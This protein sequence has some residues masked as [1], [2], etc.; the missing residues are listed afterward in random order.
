M[1][2][3]EGFSQPRLPQTHPNLSNQRQ[4]VIQEMQTDCR[5]SILSLLNIVHIAIA[6]AGVGVAISTVLAF[7]QLLI[8]I[9]FT[10]W[11]MALLFAL[12]GLMVILLFGQGYFS[13]SQT[14][15]FSWSMLSSI[16]VTLFGLGVVVCILTATPAL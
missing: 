2:A 1:Q 3:S 6:L 13:C 14:Q 15:Q 16:A 12:I 11:Q 9:Y 4:F 7:Q 5:W 10:C 8:Q